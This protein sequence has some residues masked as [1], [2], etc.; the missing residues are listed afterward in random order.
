MTDSQW[1]DANDPQSKLEAV[2][3]AGDP[4]KL[5]LFALAC[6]RRIEHLLAEGPIR[7]LIGMIERCAEG[8]FPERD[9]YWAA[10]DRHAASYS[11]EVDGEAASAVLSAAGL[12][13]T[14]VVGQLPSGTELWPVI[15]QDIAEPRLVSAVKLVAVHSAS[16][17]AWEADPLGYEA[18]R[19]AASD[20]LDGGN[21]PVPARS[22]ARQTATNARWAAALC[23][24]ESEQAAWLRELFGNAFRSGP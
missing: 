2:R 9:L 8:S 24:A 3:H 1:R 7:E 4:R 14:W 19:E 13:P 17:L 10:W 23:A 20:D 21:W 16:A 22:I 6:C 5:R 18:A 15:R 11:V 12:P